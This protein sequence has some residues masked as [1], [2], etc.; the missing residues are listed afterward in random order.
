[1]AAVYGNPGRYVPLVLAAVLIAVQGAWAKTVVLTLQ[2]TER[3]APVAHREAT[4]LLSGAF[5]WPEPSQALE[6]KR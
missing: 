4:L 1:M 5:A 6:K 2:W 3:G